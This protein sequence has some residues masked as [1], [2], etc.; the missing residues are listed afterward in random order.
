M[1]AL[2]SALLSWVA[3]RLRSGAELELIA[4]RHQVAVLN[5]PR[6][7]R[8]RLYGHRSDAV[9]VALPGVARLVLQVR[10]SLRRGHPDRMVAY[11]SADYPGSSS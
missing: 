6:S 11:S 2:I 8:L 3:C 10:S 4:L 9:G 5:R 7:G 1:L